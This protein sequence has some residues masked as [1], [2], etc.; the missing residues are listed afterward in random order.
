MSNP[1]ELALESLRCS[2]S[3]L[4]RKMG[5]HRSCI[6]AW[7]RRNRVPLSSVKR[8]SE[9]SGV[10]ANLLSPKFFPAPVVVKESAIKE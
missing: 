9:V 4:A 5:V 3:E 10:P 8:L 7:R 1:V 2:Q 6:S